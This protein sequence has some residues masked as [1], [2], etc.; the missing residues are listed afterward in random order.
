MAALRALLCV[1]VDTSYVKEKKKKS[2]AHLVI[3]VC[4]EVN[5]HQCERVSVEEERARDI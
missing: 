2:E 4:F 3:I 1:S 5:V